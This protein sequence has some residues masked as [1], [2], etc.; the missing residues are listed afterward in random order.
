[1][2]DSIDRRT[3]IEFWFRRKAWSVADCV[4]K[5]RNKIIATAFIVLPFYIIGLYYPIYIYLSRQETK[6][7]INVSEFSV[8]FILFLLFWAHFTNQMLNR[9]T[10]GKRYIYRLIGLCLSIGI[11]LAILDLAGMTMRWD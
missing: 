3:S 6:V 7:T 4:R 10:K 8:F 5:N 1:M 9:F 11:M 2:L